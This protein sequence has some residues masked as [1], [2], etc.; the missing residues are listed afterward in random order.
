MLN[1]RKTDYIG[2]LVL[3]GLFLVLVEASFFDKGLVVSLLFSVLFIVLGNKWKRRLGGRAFLWIGWISFF[4]S[5][6]NMM[7]LKFVLLALSFYFILV[8]Y[9]SKKSPHYIQPSIKESTQN[10]TDE[11]IIR[12]QPLF[13]NQL[14][15]QK[16]TPEQ[17]YEWN[18]INI[19][20]G[21]G[22]TVI[23][24]SN[25]VLPQ[26]ESVISIRQFVGNI[27]ILVPYEIEVSVYHSVIVGGT[28]IFSTQELNTFNQ[29]LFY[30]TPLYREKEQKIKIITSMFIGNLE[31]KRV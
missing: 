5:I 8:F 4:F 30:Q 18:D 15:E 6:I 19:H 25:T 20:S 1:N 22:D 24:L 12:R 2:G 31:V 27:T 21:I 13:S 14:F 26:G 29:T 16:N 28:T 11:T 10:E 3:I 7:T 17:P 9:K 23:D